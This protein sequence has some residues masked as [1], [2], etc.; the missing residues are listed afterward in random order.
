MTTQLQTRTEA[1]AQNT[2]MLNTFEMM[3]K[4]MRMA[5]FMAKSDI[6]PMHYRGK[7]ANCFIAIQSAIRMNQDP[8]LVMGSTFVVSGTLA[9]KATFV[10]SLANTSGLY[11]GGIRYITK[12]KGD[13][14]QVTAWTIVKATNERIEY[15]VSMAMATAENW[16]KNAKYKT[17]PELMLTY[18]AACFLIRVH[19]PEILNGMHMVEELEDVAASAGTPT[20]KQAHQN[21]A[22]TT[23]K[24]I[25]ELGGNIPAETPEEPVAPK[26]GVP[27][28]AARTPEIMVEPEV[29]VS[30][31]EQLT[32]LIGE[33]AVPIEVMQK[34]LTKAGV[35]KLS[36]MSDAELMKCI[37]YVHEKY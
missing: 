35:N 24:L 30:C 11:N 36:D 26:M 15:T 22:S 21:Y 18:R 28:D 5:D 34:W 33:K 2:G 27:E 8:M 10:I 12:G 29:Q 25:A 14:L 6:I 13:D 7:P 23:D 17:L 32:M 16:T 19:N 4:S 1:P 31:A 9:L 37:A 3:E 20:L